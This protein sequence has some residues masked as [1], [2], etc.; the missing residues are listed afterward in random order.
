LPD[1]LK[2]LSK[3]GLADQVEL[4][5]IAPQ[6][7]STDEMSKLWTAFQTH[8]RSAA[9]YEA[10]VVLIDSQAS[11]KSQLRVRERN[12][13]AHPLLR[14]VVDSIVSSL[15]EASPIHAGDTILV[16]GS[17]LGAD[18]TRVRIRDA[19]VTLDP[20]DVTDTELRVSLAGHDLPAGLQPLQVIHTE[21]MGTPAA[22][23][24]GVE[25]NLTSFVLTPVITEPLSVAGGTLTIETTPGLK[26]GQKIV[27]LLNQLLASP[28]DDDSAAA[29][30]AE[31][32]PLEADAASVD[33][34][35]TGL[36]AGTYLVRVRVDGAE[37]TL[38]VDPATD[39]YD[40][41]Q[42]TVP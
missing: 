5:K 19:V 26:A 1:S 18:A 9:A 17:Q 36:T 24:R 3:S 28:S 11:T 14:P 35:L 37:S 13:Y 21:S 20:A 6:P 27:L 29:Y 8:Y 38:A 30:S 40:A 22:D 12:V 41:P 33:F 31:L 15:G 10:S 4:I 23:H 34:P 16:R 39:R 7:L 42:V 2:D 25:S 32:P